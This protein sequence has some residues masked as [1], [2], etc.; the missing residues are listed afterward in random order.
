MSALLPNQTLYIN[1]LNSSIKKPLL[2]KS[3]L[4]LFTTH[5]K[6]LSVSI[7]RSK[8]MRGQAHVTLSSLPEATA[9]LAACQGFLLFDKPMRVQYAKEKSDRVLKSEGKYEPKAVKAARA[10]KRAAA[11]EAAAADS[12]SSA[13]AAAAAEADAGE[14]AGKKPKLE[15][16]AEASPTMY[17][18][19]PSL[20]AECTSE[21][22]DVLFSPYSGYVRATCPREGL[23]FVEFVDDA[24]AVVAREALQG[25][26]LTPTEELQLFFGKK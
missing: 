10:D 22:L 8:S 26:K 13:A 12:S 3:L 20:P 21:M 6:I 9:A 5:G 11:A 19:A 25:F 14:P 1:N 16:D 4:N 24:A 18:W 23:G 15:F 17:L 2:L 7:I